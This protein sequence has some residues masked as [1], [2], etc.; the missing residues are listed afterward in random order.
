MQKWISKLDW[1][2]VIRLILGGSMIVVG[3]QSSDYIPALFGLFFVIY[4]II[5][6]KYKIGC[7]YNNCGYQ[8]T[9]L[10][11]HDHKSAEIEYTEIK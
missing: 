3:Y 1:I 4:S 11:Q 10:N 8:T 6:A 2:L 5:G 7:G 9:R